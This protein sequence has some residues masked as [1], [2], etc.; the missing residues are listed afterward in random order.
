[1]KS[2]LDDIV[3]AQQD[4]VELRYHENLTN[5][6]MAQK[7]RVDQA[8]SST[9]IGVGVRV[10]A[11]GVWGF[12]STSKV[13]RSSI[14]KAIEKAR[15]SAKELAKSRQKKVAGLRECKLSTDDFLEE[16]FESLKAMALSDKMERVIETE[17]ELASKSSYINTA[18]SRYSEIFEDKI[19]VSSDGASCRRRLVRSEFKTYAY[20]SKGAE[21]LSTGRA[22]GVTGG[23]DCL[24]SHP[25]SHNI[26]EDT[27]KEVVDLLSAS[28]LSGGKRKVILSPSLVGL[29]CHEAIGH[30]VEADFVQAGSIAQGKLGSQV[31]SPLVTLYDS[32]VPPFAGGPGGLIPFDDEGVPCDRTAI[33]EKGKLNSYLHDR[34][35]AYEFGVEPTGNSRAW[36]YS[37]EPLIRMTNTYIEPGAHSFD[38]MLADSED[39]LLIEGAGSGQADATG[40]FMFGANC[41]Y[42]IKNGR[43]E[44]MYRE[45]TLSGIAFD[46]LNSVDMVSKDFQWDLGSG[47]CGKGQPAKVDAGGPYLRCVLNIGGRQ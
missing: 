9:Q 5:A 39:C 30:T 18:I 13:D 22:V 33:I 42:D 35:S 23:W 26:I 27:A 6:V 29:L 14:E 37:D 1:M 43:R 19:I 11:Y 47:Y 20:A 36:S 40:E 32:G 41:A 12:S 24:F 4:Y 2:F 21:Q 44:K 25:T 38:E 15:E 3:K 45:V 16:G 10:L 28:Y 8:S 31:A 46:V 7:G 34:E 17:K